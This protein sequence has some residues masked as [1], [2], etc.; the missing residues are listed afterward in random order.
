MISKFF[1]RSSSNKNNNYVV[2]SFSEFVE[3]EVPTIQRLFPDAG[4]RMTFVERFQIWSNYVTS[5]LPNV[6]SAIFAKSMYP[7]QLE[8]WIVALQDHYGVDGKEHLLVLENE[9]MSQTLPDV[10]AQVLDFLGM[11][12]HILPTDPLG[13]AKGDYVAPMEMEDT[14]VR[15]RLEEFF[16]P[17]NRQLDELLTN[18]G[19]TRMSWAKEEAVAN[20]KDTG[21]IQ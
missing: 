16:G 15:K 21:G 7:I 6:A 20:G 12:P 17:Y 5:L 8:Q 18:H 1:P 2:P 3:D 11:E 19:L 9:Q 4:I 14:T 13:K 10:Y